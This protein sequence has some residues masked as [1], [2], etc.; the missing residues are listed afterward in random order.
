MMNTEQYLLDTVTAAVK[1]LYGETNAPLQIQ[2]TRKEFEGDYTLV[3]FR[4][5]RPAAN[6]PKQRQPKSA[7]TSRPMSPKS[8][9]TMSSRD[10]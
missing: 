7:N 1:A 9:D 8:R 4:C 6:R 5:S 10:S 2:K 3:V